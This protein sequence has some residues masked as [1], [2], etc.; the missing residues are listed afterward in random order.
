MIRQVSRRLSLK[1]LSSSLRDLSGSRHEERDVW[2]P[3]PKGIDA[4][5]LRRNKSETLGRLTFKYDAKSF[6]HALEES[7]YTDK[8]VLLLF[9]ATQGAPDAVA[10]GESVLSH[11]LLIEAI[12]SLFI[13]VF[14]DVAGVSPDDV[15]LL[16]RYHEN[17]HRGTVIRIVNSKG[18]DLA[19]KLEGSRCSVGNIAKAMREALDRKTL[20]VPKYLKLLEEEHL[21]LVDVPSKTVR[22]TARV[23][24]VTTKA[25]KKAEIGFAE[26]SGVIAVECGKISGTRAVKVTYNPDV[27][28]CKA[29]FLHAIFHVFVESVY[30]TDMDQMVSLQSQVLKVDNPPS[31]E[32]LGSTPFSRGKDPKHF[33][34]TTLLRYVPLTALQALQANLAISKNQHELLDD[35]LSPRQLAIFEAV[36]TKR[37]RRETVDVAIAEA[38]RKLQKDG[39]FTWN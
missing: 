35:L 12:E 13:P 15:Q 18:H 37:P 8:P 23:V 20:Q 28:D 22:T 2:V 31:L 26:L 34:R 36:E 14:V 10:M 3:Y 21:A 7:R 25:T 29:V 17:C 30:W 39:V 11:P 27:I 33:L 9:Q 16:A 19:V 24:V 4:C 38:W 1:S 32:Q 6:P 5:V